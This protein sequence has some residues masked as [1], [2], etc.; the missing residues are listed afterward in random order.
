MITFAP[1]MRTTFAF[2]LWTLLFHVLFLPDAVTD[3]LTF[4]G[5]V[6]FLASALLILLA[7]FAGLHAGYGLPL[8]FLPERPHFLPVFTSRQSSLNH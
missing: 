4:F 2:T 7:T 5:P 1:T 3:H 6:F 8:S